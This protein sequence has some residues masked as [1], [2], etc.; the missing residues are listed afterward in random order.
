MGEKIRGG[1]GGGGGN[2]GKYYEQKI[3][4]KK[5]REKIYTGNK[6]GKQKVR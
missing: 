5:V 4:G 2:A 3:T 1:G 6:Y